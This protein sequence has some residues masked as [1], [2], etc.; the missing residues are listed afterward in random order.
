MLGMTTPRSLARQAGRLS[1][2]RL[3]YLLL[4]AFTLLMLLYRLNELPPFFTDEGLFLSTAA[5]MASERVYATR[6]LYTYYVANISVGPP[7][8][9]PLAL[10]FTLF[11]EGL[12]QGRLVMVLFSVVALLL[13]ARLASRL[14]GPWAGPLAWWLVLGSAWPFFPVFARMVFGEVP[15]LAMLFAALLCWCEYLDDRRGWPAYLLA[16]L[17]LGLACAA[18]PQML[19]IVPAFGLLALLDLGHYRLL[20]LRHFLGLAGLAAAALLLCYCFQF[21]NVGW[22]RYVAETSSMAIQAGSVFNVD[23]QTWLLRSRL[24]LNERTFKLLVIL[25]ALGWHARRLRRPELAS[26]KLAAPLLFCALWLAWNVTLATIMRYALVGY[27]VGAVL[28]AGAVVE[29]GPLLWA[30]LRPMGRRLMALSAALLLLVP[31][32]PLLNFLAQRP[33]DGVYEMA[34]YIREQL[35]ADAR[36]ETL[37]WGID[38]FSG[39]LTGHMPIPTHLALIEAQNYLDAEQRAAAV[40]YDFRPNR[41]DYLLLGPSSGNVPAYRQAIARG[42]AVLVVRFEEYALF[43]ILPSAYDNSR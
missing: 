34:A 43:K 27:V 25:A 4:G 7:V 21:I 22:A 5:T 23:P 42:E 10:V 20:G 24:G 14:W 26:L 33:P 1:A 29:V 36:I 12:V 28:V 40:P 2:L 19:L 31:L 16:G 18:K 11:G 17:G 39:R 37:E 8:I 13:A 38:I 41:P 15:A 35:P 9:V 30:R 6:S 32:P 3:S